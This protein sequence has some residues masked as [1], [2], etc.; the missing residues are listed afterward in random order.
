MKKIIKPF[1][2]ATLV[3]SITPPALADISCTAT[4]D[5]ASL[6]YTQTAAECNGK[7]SVIC[8]FDTNKYYCKKTP[9][10]EGCAV[11]SYLYTDKSCSATRD[12]NRTLVGIVFDPVKKLAALTTYDKISS[13]NNF[14]VDF[15]NIEHCSPTDALVNCGT[16]GKEN[17]KKLKIYPEFSSDGEIY[18]VSGSNITIAQNN[19]VISTTPTPKIRSNAIKLT[20]NND[21]SPSEYLP[22]SLW[23]GY[24]HWYIPSLKELQTLQDNLG[25][26]DLFVLYN[27]KISS[28]TAN[29]HQ[30]VLTLN[31][32]KNSDNKIGTSSASGAINGTIPIINYGNTTALT[33]VELKSNNLLNNADKQICIYNDQG[34]AKNAC[35]DYRYEIPLDNQGYPICGTNGYKICDKCN[36][37]L[38]KCCTSQDRDCIIPPVSCDNPINN[39]YYATSIEQMQRTCGLR[40]YF[41]CKTT[42]YNYDYTCCEGK[43]T[44]C[45][46]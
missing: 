24:G 5:C 33:D 23:Y 10:I 40:G 1:L 14:Q 17:S 35:P 32:G 31:V 4:P 41:I 11:G 29:D 44:G 38:I 20:S 8:P 2:S 39:K 15:T 12:N 43:Q 19:R 13:I 30:N 45:T 37:R 34:K 28:S 3:L 22:S 7:A 27:Q 25:S 18:N 42:A 16:D 26:S 6:G 36:G 46:Q 21:V 9:V